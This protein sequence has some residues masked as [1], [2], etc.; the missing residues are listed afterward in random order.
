MSKLVYRD[1]RVSVFVDE[2]TGAETVLI[3]RTT[4]DGQLVPLPNFERLNEAHD[5]LRQIEDTT[6]SLSALGLSNAVRLFARLL[7]LL[8]RIELRRPEVD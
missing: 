6:G 7:R 3:G 1:D 8:I 2:E 4:T 5:A